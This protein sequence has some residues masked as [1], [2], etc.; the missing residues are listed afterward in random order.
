MKKPMTKA[1]P[2]DICG[3]P[4][5]VNGNETFCCSAGMY[6]RDRDFARAELAALIGVNA[7]LE[8]ARGDHTPEVA[9]L[10]AA[11][12]MYRDYSLVGH[13]KVAAK[14]LNAN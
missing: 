14:A 6:K 10:R 5:L 3:L 1:S 11:L 12:E 4:T 2:C 13:G 9:R 8:A 7:Q